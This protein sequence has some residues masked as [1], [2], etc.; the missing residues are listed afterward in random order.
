MPKLTASQF[1][2]KLVLVTCGCFITAFGINLFIRT[3]LG[4]DPVSLWVQGLSIALRLEYGDA[5][6]LSNACLLVLAL[7]LAFR[8]IYFGTVVASLALG[9]FISL[10]KPF[11]EANLV[12]PADFGGQLVMLAA[13]IVI[14][15]A[16]AGLTVSLRFGVG[17]VDAVVLKLSE[18]T[19]VHYRYLRIAA[20]SLFV[21]AGVAIGAPFGIGTVTSA[22]AI[23]PCVAFFA[24]TY[25][26]TLLRVLGITDPRNEFRRAPREE[27]QSE[28]PQGEADASREAPAP[29]F[30][31]R[32]GVD[33]GDPAQAEEPPAV[34]S[35]NE[36]PACPSGK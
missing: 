5:S 6:L 13:A 33:P 34:A 20:D 12:F 21:L 32:R 27:P 26:R 10:Q 35:E 23:G 8:N 29:A 11:V 4:A 28:T 18:R 17:S 31:L 15:A 30:E 2:K 24:K 1:L 9:P 36:C 22:V 25:N 7:C 16:G 14:L 3:G 19:G